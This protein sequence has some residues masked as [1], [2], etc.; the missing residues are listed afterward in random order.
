[1]SAKRHST[2]WVAIATALVALLAGCSSKETGNDPSDLEE[3]EEIGGETGDDAVG[4]PDEAAGDPDPGDP[5][6]DPEEEGEDPTADGM[7]EE[8]ELPENAV[9]IIRDRWGVPHI[10]ASSERAAG[11]GYG[12]AQATDQLEQVLISLWTAQGRRTEIEGEALLE[13]DRSMRLLRLVDDVEEAFDGYPVEIQEYLQGFAQGINDY[14]AAHPDQVP[15]W[16][17]PIEPSWPIALARLFLMV[18]Q[19]DRANRERGGLGPGLVS[20][21]FFGGE[22]EKLGSNAWAVTAD[23]SA[24]GVGLMAGD[25]HMPYYYEW[26]LY[27][28]HIRAPSFEIAG[29]GFVG[30]PVPFFGRTA[31]VAWSW[32]WN[33]PDHADTYRLTLDPEDPGRYLLDGTSTAFQTE[34][35]QFAMPD[36]EVVSETLRWSVHGPVVHLDA[37]GG[38]GLAYWMSGFGQADTPIQ[39]FEMVQAQNLDEFNQA[40]GRLQFVTFNS[41][42]ADVQGSVQYAWNAR[43]PRRDPGVEARY[44]LDGSRS[45][46]LWDSEDPIPFDQLP[47]VRD[48]ET[49]WVQNC[50]NSWW[51][52][53]GTDDDPGPQ[54]LPQGISHDELDTERAWRV[55]QALGGM[56]EMSEAEA[57]ALLTEG[58]AIP[59]GPMLPLIAESWERWGASHARA[60]VI[61]PVVELLG[62]WDGSAELWSA[63][64]TI[65]TLWAYEMFHSVEFPPDALEWT[66][67]VLTEELGGRILDAIGSAVDTASE[68]A[69]SWAIPWGLIHVIKLGSSRIPVATGQYPAV[70]LMNCNLDPSDSEALYCQL[71]SAYTFLNVME[72]PI[73]TYSVMPFANTDN[74]ELP[75]FGA[76]THLF[77]ERSTKPLPFTDDQIAQYQV[78]EELL[79]LPQD[80]E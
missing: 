59:A 30:T 67:A 34:V 23:R 19:I 36:G 56:E 22:F 64:P 52:T 8:I 70:S 41:V 33:L 38:V 42:A 2:R 62:R 69:P 73:R 76:M 11:Y 57:L 75:Y 21:A 29:A 39:F 6:T 27:E 17:E 80:G 16:A 44:P 53:T 46:M 37:E 26:R 43:L 5:A 13:V 78:S 10:L 58:D 51:M 35:A 32:T 40:M 54:V 28:G 77:A 61:E 1:M 12:W 9:R 65:F 25:P 20:L 72:E 48:P 4:E 66:P 50:N 71:G 60:E 74:P 3:V 14:M 31:R 7:W 24:D 49:G 47:A 55:R 79:W 63:A 45:E 18:A 68:M 15:E